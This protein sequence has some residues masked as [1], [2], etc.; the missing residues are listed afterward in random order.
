MNLVWGGSRLH[1]LHRPAKLDVICPTSRP[2]TKCLRN[3]AD[4]WLHPLECFTRLPLVE[5]LWFTERSSTRLASPLSFCMILWSSIW[6]GFQMFSASFLWVTYRCA[7]FGAI[8]DFGRSFM[9]HWTS[10]VS[11]C[12][13]ITYSYNITVIQY[14]KDTRALRSAKCLRYF[15]LCQSFCSS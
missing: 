6:H 14:A 5:S 3:L 11:M 15:S 1:I 4:F 9:D 10:Y 12:K 2:V 8:S 13:I 7:W